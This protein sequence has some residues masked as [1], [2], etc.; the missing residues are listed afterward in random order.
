VAGASLEQHVNCGGLSGLSGEPA[1]SY[2][3][4]GRLRWAPRRF[5]VVAV[6][7]LLLPVLA[8]KSAAQSVRGHWHRL[9]PEG[10][11][12]LSLALGSEGSLYLGTP[13]GHIFAST[14]AARHWELRGRVSARLD[15]VVQRLLIDARSPQRL[16]AA[17]WFQEPA[18]G[19]GIFR[20][21]DAGRTWSPAGLGGEAVRAL[22]QSASQ[23]EIL[24]AGTRSGVFLSTDAGSSWEGISPPGD[25]ELRNID[26]L[27][28]D[29]HNARTIYVGTYHLPWKT[30]DAGKTWAPV[31]AGMIDDSDVMALRVDVHD[32]A[33]LFASACSGIYRSE[34]AGGQWTKLEGVP[35]AARRTQ[36]IV[37]DPA[38]PH[39]LYAGTTEGLWITRDSGESWTRATPREW[40]VNAIAVLPARADRP[41]RVILGTDDGGI[42][43]SDDAGLHFAPSNEGF[44]HRLIVAFAV[45][46]AQPGHWLARVG[47][48]GEPLLETGDSGRSWRPMPSLPSPSAARIFGTMKGWFAAPAVGGLW[49]YDDTARQWRAVRLVRPSPTRSRRANSQDAR[50]GSFPIAAPVQP[51]VVHDLRVAETRLWAATSEG[52]WSGD[53]R[54]AT[55]NPVSGQKASNALALD[56]E[57]SGSDATLWVITSAGLSRFS[58]AGRFANAQQLPNDAGELRWV[59]AVEAGARSGLLVGAVH[60]VYWWQDG[61]STWRLLARGLPATEL[62]PL[63]ISDTCWLLAGKAG[64]LYLSVNAGISWLR[65]DQA[66]ETSL[67]LAGTASGGGFI[68]ASRSEGLLGW[69]PEPNP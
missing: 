28:F 2:V 47:S 65:L 22:E 45:D 10:G 34:N 66:N 68:A 37:Q 16:L 5:F 13:D 64:G 24:V 54:T 39:V 62:S 15:A 38:D 35:Y 21:E 18:A 60:G 6:F 44:S 30:V 8:P 26:S 25:P 27:A 53:A 63:L 59:R 43:T 48:V 46:P 40:V 32:P 20:S 57:F 19:G 42:Q 7:A 17:V 11:Q 56:I 29:P 61:S 4:G 12:V 14:D 41:S 50:R 51:P 49:R 69:E 23:P 52:L 3:A 1:R 9:G 67:F 58:S 33:R 55:L 31:A 36:D